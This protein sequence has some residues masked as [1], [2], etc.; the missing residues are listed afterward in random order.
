MFLLHEYMMSVTVSEDLEKR[1]LVK[2]QLNMLTLIMHVTP[3]LFADNLCKQFVPEVI[4]LFSHSTQ[5][6]TKFILLINVKMPT[7]F[8]I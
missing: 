2:L 7:I 6:I 8:G 3:L 5:L 1:A 4:K